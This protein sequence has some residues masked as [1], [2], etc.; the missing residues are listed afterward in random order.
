MKIQKLRKR[1]HQTVSKQQR[2][3][4]PIE[5]LSTILDLAPAN[6]GKSGNERYK[7]QVF[8]L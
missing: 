5:H 4:N 2:P 7:I 3:M 1:I 6:C 8:S